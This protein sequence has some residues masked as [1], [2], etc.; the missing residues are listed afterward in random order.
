MSAHAFDKHYWEQHWSPASGAAGR[1][2]PENPYLVE[3]TRQLVAGTALDAGCGAGAEV[4]WLAR[5]GWRVTGA[6]ISA[7]A[8]KAAAERGRD[9]GVSDLV[10]WVET[11]L[12]TWSPP[13]RW[14]LVM[15]CYA[16][17]TIPQLDF[18]RR[19]AEWVVPGGALLIIGHRSNDHAGAGHHP[20]E[21]TVTL[22]H[23]TALFPAPDWEIQSAWENT[24]IVSMHHGA[25]S[26]LRDV[27]VRARRGH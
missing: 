25:E 18:Y 1:Q 9:A 12:T 7:A 6:D 11:D 2:V 13:Q 10:T 21:S 20:P 14:D 19:I 22:E 15:T 23:I 8:L 17:P 16:H 4:I 3:E 24:R 5:H 26:T 27:I